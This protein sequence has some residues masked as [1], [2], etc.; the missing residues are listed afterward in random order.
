MGSKKSKAPDY[1][2]AAEESGKWALEAAKWE[3]AANRPNMFTPWG[4]QTYQGTP[5]QPGYSTTVTLSPQQQQALDLQMAL[6]TGRSN[7]GLGLMGQAGSELQTP[8]DF[9]NTLPQVG[10]APNVPGF[11]GQGLPD[12]GRVPPPDPSQVGGVQ[13]PEVQD[14]LGSAYDPGFAN[15][16]FQ[17]QMSLI[18]PTH[19][20]KT[21][22]MD[23]QL[24]N[25]GLVP[26]TEAY[27]SAMNN[28]RTQQ[29]EEINRLSADAID[30]GRAEQQ[31]EY[32]RALGGGG[33]RFGQEAS[34]ADF[35]S[36][37]QSG[38]FGA[39][40]QAS[41]YADEQR[42]QLAQEQMGFGQLGFG[43][44][45]QQAQFQNQLRQASIAEQLQREGWS[46]NKI[47][48]V[49]SGQQVGMPGMPSFANVNRPQTPDFLG[50]ANMQGQFDLQNQQNAM[51]PWNALGGLGAAYLGNR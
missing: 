43:Q 42:A 4:A 11:Y 20:A 33:Q 46:L 34:L 12:M 25:Q 38:G 8:G 5:G 14:R 3:A 48:A 30:R 28:L 36:Q 21:E 41:R 23:V 44:E 10:G 9:W 40:M 32:L 18:A 39:Q 29:G 17:R 6:Q 31:A 27:D 45:M 2:G 35:L 26:G 1:R 19:E 24:R 13:G 15:Q 22:A 37:Q 50:A 51:A 47:N 16:A 49:L 7:I